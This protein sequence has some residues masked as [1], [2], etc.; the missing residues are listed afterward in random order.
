MKSEYNYEKKKN[1][2]EL[3]QPTVKSRQ[4]NGSGLHSFH[5]GQQLINDD[6]G[7]FRRDKHHGRLFAGSPDPTVRFKSV[8]RVRNIQDDLPNYT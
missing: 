1:F 7:N 3:L 6:D 4:N 5:L 8:Q 2:V